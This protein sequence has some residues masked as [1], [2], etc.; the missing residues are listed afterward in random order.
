VI[1][2]TTIPMICV[3]SVSATAKVLCE[4]LGWQ[5]THGGDEFDE[6]ADANG[7]RCVWLHTLGV[8]EHPRFADNH[9][10]G[11]GRGVAL[12]VF[13]DDIDAVYQRARTLGLK[14]VEPLEQNPNAGFR[15]FSFVESNGYCFSVA[16]R[17][18]GGEMVS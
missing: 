11:L 9:R 4:L 12:Y 1:H 18:D 14:I 6:L 13:V 5:S 16:E 8:P 3:E 10:G 7:R 2:M 17:R 15:E